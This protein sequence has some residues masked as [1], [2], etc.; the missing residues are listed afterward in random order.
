MPSSHSIAVDPNAIPVRNAWYLLLYAWDL[1]RWKDWCDTAAETAPNLL[2]LLTRILVDSTSELLRRQLSR[3]HQMTVREVPGIRGRVDFTASLR[4]MTFNVGRAVCAFSE[5]T[6]DS[7]RNRVIRGT[8]ERLF[9]DERISAGA[10]SDYT[11]ALRHDIWSVLERM[12]GVS[13]VSVSLADFSKIR[14]GRNDDSYQ[15]PLAVCHLILS[16]EMPTQDR[17]DHAMAALLRD[18]I[19]F[20]ELFEKFVRNFL[21]YSLADARVASETLSWHDE[22]GSAI[23]PQMRTDVSIEWAG[24]RTGRLVLDT[25]YYGKTLSQRFG[26]VVKFHS[27]HLY[28][29][30]TYLRTQEHRGGHYVNCPG[31]IL[32]PTTSIRVDERMRV[33]GHEI[34]VATLDLAQPWVD[35]ERELLAFVGGAR[36][37]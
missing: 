8:L 29:L 2:G 28:Q 1:A 4:R 36:A 16:S 9:T 31:L 33:Q 27:A 13:S 11:H 32:Y 5:L 12:Q 7:P 10:S 6:V 3:A 26:N 21:R 18:E 20:S 30:Y 37:T 34:R 25:K 14:L 17:G 24:S 15:L 22:I 19:R 23:V 35:I